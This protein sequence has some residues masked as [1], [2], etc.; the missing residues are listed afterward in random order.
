MLPAPDFVETKEQIRG[1]YSMPL[2]SRSSPFISTPRK[3]KW[4]RPMADASAVGAQYKLTVSSING[5]IWI[6]VRRPFS[7]LTALSSTTFMPRHWASM[8]GRFELLER[9]IV[10]QRNDPNR[11]NWERQYRSVITR[12]AQLDEKLN[13]TPLAKLIT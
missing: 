13:H 7:E 9:L 10:G 8:A 1:I 2:L 3:V 4:A 5:P 11:E 6:T 12:I